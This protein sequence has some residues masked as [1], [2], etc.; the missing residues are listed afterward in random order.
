MAD[1]LIDFGKISHLGMEMDRNRI[2][3]QNS[4]QQAQQ[5]RIQAEH[6]QQQGL[7]KA[8]DELSKFEESPSYAGLQADRQIDLTIAKGN[9]L[10]SL[11]GKELPLPSKAEL[12]GGRDSINTMMNTM[13]TGTPEQ[14]RDV[15]TKAAFEN[16]KWARLL[17]DDLNKAGELNTHFQEVDA[18]LKLNAAQLERLNVQN[19]RYK[20][21]QNLFTEH[22]SALGRVTAL[23]T[24]P[25]FSKDFQAVLGM[26]R[27]ESRQA[28]L[29]LHPAFAKEFDSA[30]APEKQMMGFVDPNAAMVTGQATTPGMI[31]GLMQ[32]VE[33]RSLAVRDAQAKD[34]NGQA[35]I[36]MADELAGYSAVQKARQIEAAWLQD[37]YNKT[38]WKAL[39]KSEQDLRILQSSTGKKLSEVADQRN[40][41]AQTKFDQQTQSKLAEADLQDA[42]I[43]GLNNGQDDNQALGSA[44]TEV[45]KR[46]PGVPF[47]ATKILNPAY[48]GK[49]TVE[50]VTYDKKQNVKEAGQLASVLGVT[51]VNYL[52]SVSS[53]LTQA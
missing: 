4:L 26:E 38:T 47:D 27:P 41:L 37:P 25:R 43:Q 13:K 10:Q 48:K 24:E 14:V 52:A 28:Y 12:L 51:R 32:H 20:L 2:Y 44:I 34:P 8:Y 5:N 19:G 30:L 39:K 29:A 49:Q 31:A 35:P 22:A 42:Y 50:N 23:A 40:V 53:V 17:F 33:A 7:S 45:K 21:Q 18:K 15:T 11:V 9:I 3:E 36:E 1:S 6:V 46:Y 16:P